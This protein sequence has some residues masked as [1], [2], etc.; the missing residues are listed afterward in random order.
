MNEY[1]KQA[2]D[3][4]ENCGATI[5]I[6]FL[7]KETNKSWNDNVY[8]NTYMATIKTPLGVMK[9]KFWDSIYSTQ[10]N[11]RP[12]EYDILA[13]LQKYDVGSFEDFVNEFGYEIDESQS[14]RNS[15]QIYNA[16]C[17]EYEKVCRCFTQKQ[18]EAM[19]EIQ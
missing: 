4:L 10:N 7:G 19:Q 9:V 14:R 17:R 8:R 6:T 12:T 16:V 3:F 1:Q 13:C 18:I 11:E 15:K 2:K 5:K